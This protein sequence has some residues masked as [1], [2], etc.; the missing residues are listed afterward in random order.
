MTSAWEWAEFGHICVGAELH[1]FE[2]VPGDG[3][4]DRQGSDGSA[5]P[6]G[7]SGSGRPLDSGVVSIEAWRLPVDSEAHVSARSGVDIYSG[8]SARYTDQVIGGS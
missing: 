1:Y 8:S 2:V 5:A 3:T 4:G 7:N 6:L